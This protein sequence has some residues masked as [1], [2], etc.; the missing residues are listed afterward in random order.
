MPVAKLRGIDVHYEDTGKG[1]AT[2][3]I[4]HG[5]MG[6][7]ARNPL[8]GI[9]ALKIA[10]RGLRVVSYDA[11]G[12]GL[13]GYSRDSSSYR[14]SELAE[15][16]VALLDHLSV[17]EA[18]IVGISMGAGTGLFL[19]AKYPQRVARLIMIS[20]P[21]LAGEMRHTRV[22]MACVAGGFTCFGVRGAAWLFSR[23][24]RE[25]ERVAARLRAQRRRAI[26]PAIQGLVFSRE[27]ITVKLAESVNAPMLI[28][29]H[30]GDAMHPEASARAYRRKIRH[31]KLLLGSDSRHWQSRDT[32]LADLVASFAAEG[33]VPSSAR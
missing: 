30:S 9:S 29:G 7:V 13:S 17:E 31:S 4:A 24:G 15:D 3:V 23:V 21:A 12:H 8:S 26:V 6:S 27:Q 18:T 28:L 19:A 32:E 25:R 1:T 10:R 16:L 2:V 33:Q 11:R 20:P 5:L 22:V 14:W